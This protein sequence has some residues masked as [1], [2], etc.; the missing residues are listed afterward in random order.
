M[1]GNFFGGLMIFLDRPFEIGDWI[2]SPDKEIEG[3]VENIGWRLT[4]I[5]TF[6]K[7]PLFV[8]NGIFSNISVENAQRMQNRRIKT[9]IS[10]RYD[11]V[12]KLKNIL[13]GIKEMLKN[14]PE[15]DQ[16][17]ESYVNLINLGPSALEIQIYTF[18]KITKW[19]P[20]QEIQ[21]DVLLKI[22]DEIKKHGAELSYP[23]STIHI[24]KDAK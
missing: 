2:R 8:P 18:T 21:E 11:D 3:T 6:D 1:L 15:I 22:L 20:Y 13:S 17:K 19:V 5:R 14:H 10:I 4:T 23:T 16:D 7:R 9:Q 24:A 12:F